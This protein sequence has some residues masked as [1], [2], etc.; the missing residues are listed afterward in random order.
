MEKD[1]NNLLQE[2]KKNVFFKLKKIFS[3]KFLKKKKK[4]D[5]KDNNT[6]D[7]IYPMW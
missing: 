2:Q 6:T 5:S 7:D 1:K 4:P 3:F